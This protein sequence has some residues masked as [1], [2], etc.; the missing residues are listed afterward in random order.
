MVSID[1][2]LRLPASSNYLPSWPGCYLVLPESKS[3]ISSGIWEV[4]SRNK[5]QDAR[6]DKSR[7]TLISDPVTAPTRPL[8]LHPPHGIQQER[9]SLAQP[10]TPISSTASPRSPPED[11]RHQSIVVQMMVDYSAVTPTCVQNWKSAA[12]VTP[13]A[14][15]HFTDKEP[16]T[17]KSPVCPAHP[18]TQ[19]QCDVLVCSRNGQQ[20]FVIRWWCWLVQ[21]LIPIQPGTPD[22]RYPFAAGPSQRDLAVDGR[23]LA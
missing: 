9:L 19:P 8:P 10:K 21:S 5:D 20:P 6:G 3:Q 22:P 12:V 11:P 15:L 4:E 2:T 1:T 16:S 14:T 17:T 23:G 18:M 13:R 7:T